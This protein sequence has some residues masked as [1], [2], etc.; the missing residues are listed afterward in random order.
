MARYFTVYA[1]QV[2]TVDSLVLVA[3]RTASQ[4]SFFFSPQAAEEQGFRA[5][6]RCQPQKATTP[7]L[8]RDKVLAAC[9]YIE[10][11]CD[12][13]PSLLELSTEVELSPSHLQRIF[14]QIVGVTPFEY[15]TAHRTER[16][17]QHLHQGEEIAHALY[18][19]GY[20][21]SSRLYEKAP[22]QLGMTPAT[23]KQHGRGAEIRYTTVNSAL[24]FLIIAATEQGLC[25]V[26][27]GETV[28]ELEDELRNEFRYASLRRTND[29][30]DWIQAL[31]DYLSGNL[32][33]PELPY[34]VKATAFQLRVWEALREIPIGTT[35]SYSD[36]ACVIGQPTAIRAVARACAT[37]PIALLVPCHRVVPKAGGL[38]GY[39]WG[40]TRKQ[41]LLD[42]EKE[43]AEAK[44]LNFQN[45]KTLDKLV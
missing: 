8:A 37:N 32:P 25:S 13:I 18:E 20:G 34:D 14:K 22:E 41:A 23:Y 16:L 27:L 11:Q 45:E 10:A 30:Q 40:V 44:V 12:R 31:V 29:V 3:N 19:V 17:K 28:A 24:G 43:Y 42:L 36:I 39:R 1:L 7:N 6:K 5:C 15:S 38:G 33:L 21:S 26:R 9:R 35:A 2:S 4:V